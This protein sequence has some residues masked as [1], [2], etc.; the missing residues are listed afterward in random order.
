MA[1]RNNNVYLRI[2]S[3]GVGD[4]GNMEGYSRV[5]LRVG[6]RSKSPLVEGITIPFV[7]KGD[8]REF[9]VRES[10]FYGVEG[11]LGSNFQRQ[12]WATL[13]RTNGYEVSGR[14]KSTKPYYEIPLGDI[15]DCLPENR[16]D[17]IDGLLGDPE[18]YLGESVD[19]LE[20]VGI[21]DLSERAN[22]VSF[23]GKFKFFR[24][25]L[26]DLAR[27]VGFYW[28]DDSEKRLERDPEEY[29]SRRVR[30]LRPSGHGKVWK[31]KKS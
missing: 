25:S 3:R 22:A 26:K 14:E 6:G 16:L 4:E 1:T 11:D 19:A 30:V 10:F 23:G 27:E 20:R 9:N 7:V 21:G 12:N 31:G 29:A 5:S 13:L 2:S 15:L 28:V 24:T 8:Q 17:E 18:L